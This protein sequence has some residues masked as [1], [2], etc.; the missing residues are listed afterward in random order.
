MLHVTGSAREEPPQPDVS[1]QLTMRFS[2]VI[3]AYEAAGTVG[4]AVASVLRQS[5]QDFEVIV[6][7]DGS[8]DQTAAAAT[9][10]GDARVRVHRQENAGPSAARN[11]GIELAR[12]EFVSML[13]SDDLW[14]PGYLEAMGAALERNP[15]A[16]LAYT[17]AWVLYVPSGRFLRATTAQLLGH[18]PAPTLPRER[19]VEALLRRNFVFNSVTVRRSVLVELG[20]YEPTMSHAED[21]ELWL[22]IVNSGYDVVRVPGQLAIWRD[23]SGS[24]SHDEE[25]MF[26]GVRRAYEAVVL[27]HDASPRVRDL[28]EERLRELRGVREQHARA[29]MGALARPRRV[30]ADVTRPLRMRRQLLARPPAEV[31]AAFPGLGSGARNGASPADA[32]ITPPVAPGPIPLGS[33]EPGLEPGEAVGLGAAAGSVALPQGWTPLGRDDEARDGAEAGAGGP[34]SLTRVVARGIGLAGTGYALSQL[35]I[36]TSYLV[37]AKLATPAAF[38][39]FAA[40]SV[41]VG[42]GMMIGE[43]GMLAALIQREDQVEE[44]MNSAFLVTALGGV[45]LSLLALAAAPLITLFFNSHEAG[46]VAAVMSGWML[47]RLIAI[48]PDAVLQRRFSFMRRV[49]IDPIAALAF[50]AGAIPA[51]AAGMGVWALVIGTYASAV[52]TVASAWIFAAWRPR[53]RM[54]NMRLWRE[55]A[56]FGR[57]VMGANLIRRVAIELPVLAV[58]RFKGPSVLGQYTYASRVAQQ[59]L[60]AVINAGGYVLLPAF[61]RLA[62]HDER[63]RAALRRALRWLCLVAFPAGMLLVPLG[64]P[65]VVLVFGRRWH[66]AGVA[67][68]ALGPYCAALSLDSIASEAWK[69]RARPDMLPRMHALSLVLTAGGVAAGVPFGLLG[70]AIGLSVSALGVGA[71][72]VLRMS[73]ALGVAVADLWSEIWPPALASVGM[74]GAF[75][76]LEQFV[77][78]ADRHAVVPG[79]ALVL[80]QALIAIAFY[81]ALLAVLAPGTARELRG[82]AAGALRRVLA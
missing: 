72:A 6:V 44:A 30:V 70:V 76:C 82:V 69:A 42:V 62:S 16:G 39:H 23:R 43:S 41:V 51:A 10:F 38:G 49:V 21:Y 37:L 64:I 53:P 1:R 12:G 75:F 26:D 8:R 73:T 11:R 4:D 15:L 19:F 17:D 20:G 67:A 80:A 2:V 55:L 34:G 79:L 59:P 13:D 36:F 66:E 68:A 25:L 48:V 60:G 35:L 65:A 52:V 74:A 71:Y 45:G 18:A 31:A 14:L 22:R 61:A 28:A 5:C 81:V 54:A 3:A 7:D 57:P 78:H 9:R 32:G 40:G 63:F 46:T 27:R 47:L 24:L 29:R 50:G 58:G 77:V 33:P 56:R